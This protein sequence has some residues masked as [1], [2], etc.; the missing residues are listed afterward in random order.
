MAIQIFGTPKS[1]ETKKAE[2]WFAER[3]IQTQIINL[4]QKHISPGELGSVVVALA[5]QSGCSRD[6]A[7]EKL[8]DTKAKDYASIKYLDESQKEEK[9]LE[10]QELLRQPIVRN[11]KAEATVGLCPEIWQVWLEGN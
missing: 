10:K 4:K 7:L 8:I 3:R 1:F 6:E 5:K 11:G 2:R 9:L